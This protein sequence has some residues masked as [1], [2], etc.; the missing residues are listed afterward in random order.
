[1]L[2]VCQ[3]PAALR[4]RFCREDRNVFS[5]SVCEIERHRTDN[6]IVALQLRLVDLEKIVV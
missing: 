5:F 2:V 3:P 1:M 6:K 4:P